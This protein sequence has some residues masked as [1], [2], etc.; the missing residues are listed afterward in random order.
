MM[1]VRTDVA[2]LVSLLSGA[3]AFALA[4]AASPSTVGVNVRAA[5]SMAALPATT[6]DYEWATFQFDENGKA[7]RVGGAFSVAGRVVPTSIAK[8]LAAPPLTMAPIK[9]AAKST[10]KVAKGAV[11]AVSPAIVLAVEKVADKTRTVAAK[12]RAVAAKTR[13]VAA[14]TN[15]AVSSAV[16]PAVALAVAKVAAKTDG[17][18][19][20]LRARRVASAAPV[21]VSWYD[22]GVRIRAGGEE[23]PLIVAPA[24]DAAA[25]ASTVAVVS[26]YDQGF[27]LK[28][29]SPEEDEAAEAA[30]N[31]R[32]WTA[33]A[34]AWGAKL[35]LAWV[36]FRIGDKMIDASGVALA[37]AAGAAAAR[38]VD[39]WE[40]AF[41]MRCVGKSSEVWRPETAVDESRAWAEECGSIASRTAAV[42]A[43]AAKSVEVA[44]QAAC[45]LT[46][47]CAADAARAVHDEKRAVTDAARAVLDAAL[48]E[49]RAALRALA[50]ARGDELAEKKVE[51][52][53]RR[54]QGALEARLPGAATV[55]MAYV[56]PSLG[57]KAPHPRAGTM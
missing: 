36:L 49:E 20:K 10:T 37:G 18:R 15:G 3:H 9:Q 14:K 13:A 8:T 57:G 33:L 39:Q 5:A 6:D 32:A 2:L 54:A 27:R 41:A 56:W 48:R 17:I 43:Y 7:K 51:W 44:A 24:G 11:T 53:L 21:V 52:R 42:E 38:E 46:A 40:A 16:S 47:Q 4:P 1:H 29:A 31:V 26:W 22:S 30:A 35:R 34:R 45:S 50:A 55:E 12:T 28:P 25:D 23:A 19:Q